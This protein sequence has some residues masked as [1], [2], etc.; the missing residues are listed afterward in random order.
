[1]KKRTISC[2]ALAV[3]MTATGACSGA[4]TVAPADTTTTAAVTA[5]A[6]T[7]TTAATLSPYTHL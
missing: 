6:T 3:L 5:E 1:M 7:V 2:I 4:Q